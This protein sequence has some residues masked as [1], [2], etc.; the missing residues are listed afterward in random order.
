MIP[1]AHSFKPRRKNMTDGNEMVS[2]PESFDFG[3][4]P[5]H[6][7]FYALVGRVASEWSQIEHVLD[8]T[9]WELSNLQSRYA[10]CIT[11]QIMGI[12]PRCKAITALIRARDLDPKLA[13]KFRQFMNS[14]YNA[15]D[16][17]ARI[18]HDPWYINLGSD[19][20]AQFR[21]M[22]HADQ[23]FGFCEVIEDEII[24]II[25]EI[26]GLQYEAV[27]LMLAVRDALSASS[28]TPEQSSP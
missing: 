6:H 28:E 13:K 3:S 14:A 25:C 19:V 20:P 22:P 18:V 27:E 21:A 11:S 16:L 24:K 17:R 2:D 23:R 10:A 12:G 1:L 7:K 26:K 4:L 5:D 15:A 9:I 8:M